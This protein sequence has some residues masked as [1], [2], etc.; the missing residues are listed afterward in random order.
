[1]DPYPARGPGIPYSQ[2]YRSPSASESPRGMPLGLPGQYSRPGSSSSQHF[3]PPLSF[4]SPQRTARVLS[5]DFGRRPVSRRESMPVQSAT[6]SYSPSR[7]PMSV[8]L[9]SPSPPPGIP[10]NPRRVTQ[11]TTVLQPITPEELSHLRS[12]AYQ[13]NPLRRKKRPAPPSWSGPSSSARTPNESDGS[14]FP[15]Q[16]HDR[17]RSGSQ[18]SGRPS[19]TPGPGL[20]PAFEDAS[21]SM[22]RNGKG[23]LKRPSDAVDEEHDTARR[24]V[25]DSQYVG[26][27]AFVADHCEST[28]SKLTLM[29]DNSR[30]EVGVENREL[31][32][33]IGL[34]KFNN[35]VKSVLIGLF[36]HQ[37]SKQDRTRANVLD[38]GCGKG[39]DLNK[40]KQAK[41]Q[42]YVGMGGSK[43]PPTLVDAELV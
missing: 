20:P 24:K 9:R 41:I 42:L 13:N 5:D 2:M 38:I 36:S 28:I 27:A 6:S 37:P 39:G 11:P 22:E 43:S 15:L 26:N 1:M 14:Y 35:W 33:I 40:W 7:P 8:P 17:R 25:S 4:E 10:Y 3:Q 30:P 29:V 12:M 16:D 19:V 34:K 32:P 21:T 18:L 31:S 23:S